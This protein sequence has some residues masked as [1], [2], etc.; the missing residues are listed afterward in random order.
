MQFSCK[1]TSSVLNYL[2]SIGEDVSPLLD[3]TSVSPESLR[4]SSQWLV[5]P[6]VERFLELLLSLP[7]KKRDLGLIEKIGHEVP[8]LRSWGILDS[9]LRMMPNSQEAFHKPE[10][11][12]SYFIFPEPP[13]ENIIRKENFISF[14]I[15][16]PAEQY[17]LT[18]RFLK[19]AF[20]SL[21]LYNGNTLAECQWTD[22]FIQL[23]WPKL[24]NSLGGENLGHQVS[25]QLLRELVD[26]LQKSQKSLEERN[27]ELTRQNEQLAK[28]SQELTQ[29]LFSKLSP[30]EKQNLAIEIEENELG[31][32]NETKKQLDFAATLKSSN[33]SIEQANF[34]KNELHQV[35]QNLARL[36]DYMVRAQQLIT[37]LSAQNKSSTQN[38]DLFKK[39]GWDFVKNEYPQIISESI[40]LLRNHKKGN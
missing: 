37:L 31:T 39:V 27:Q 10:R 24:Q 33:E 5:A 7:L 25:P 1:I 34:A 9:V 19:S 16:L 13:V 6:E 2:E 30:E 28:S 15:P 21:P 38:K 18:A 32:K 8:Y 40:N 20:E 12:L 36:H 11:F 3:I 4:D 17:P 26:D 23:Q 22:I 14:A 29:Q 35:T